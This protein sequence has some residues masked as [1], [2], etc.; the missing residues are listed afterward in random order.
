MK[1][2][3]TVTLVLPVL[4]LACAAASKQRD[5]A[6]AELAMTREL[7][8][9]HEWPAVLASVQSLHTHG[10]RSPETLTLRAA[11]YRE[12]GM[13][14]DA[15]ADLREALK[16]DRGYAPAHAALAVV[17]DLKHAGAEA[18][19]HHQ[20]AVE[21][22]PGNASY[23]NDLGFAL[24]ARG[25]YPEAVAALRRA[26]ELAPAEPRYRNNLGFAYART[27]DFTR[28]EQQFALAGSSAEKHVNLG[29]AY[30]TVGNWRQA[31][32]AYSEAVR[33]DPTSDR[34]RENLAYAARKLDRPL[35]PE[36]APSAT[37]K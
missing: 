4:L 2:S 14:E 13:L 18:E 27:G 22:A 9:R 19:E 7:A 16:L 15:E 1:P 25:K 23:L 36:L 17:L 24:Y 31:F 3:R 11:A 34:A 6:R 12:Q 32:D 29:F 28:A 21:I 5:L 33:L 8:A 30:E 20:R 37:G 26:T 35:A 10:L